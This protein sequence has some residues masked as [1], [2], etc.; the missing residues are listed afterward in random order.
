MILLSLLSSPLH[1]SIFSES[2]HL[3]DQLRNNVSA[4]FALLP[5]KIS[6]TWVGS[7]GHLLSLH[8]L[9]GAQRSK[10]PKTQ[11]SQERL[12]ER[13]G[14]AFRVCF[15]VRVKQGPGSSIAAS[16]ASRI[17]VLHFVA[18]CAKGE[19]CPALPHAQIDERQASMGHV[20]D[21]SVRKQTMRKTQAMLR[22]ALYSCVRSSDRCLTRLIAAQRE[23]GTL[24]I[25]C[26]F[27]V[28]ARCCCRSSSSLLRNKLI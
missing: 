3:P 27:V 14:V 2:A 9:L 18:C 19:S 10:T 12:S 21:G 7:T 28:C 16:V 11:E 5:R 26:S 4:H 8:R 24:A 25:L 1:P 17:S 13:A 15:V 6:H 22:H 20:N 23:R